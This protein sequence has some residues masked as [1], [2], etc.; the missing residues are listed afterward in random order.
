MKKILVFTLPLL[1]S[2]SASSQI[3]RPVKWSYAARKTAKTEAILYLLLK[4]VGISTPKTLKW[5]A[6]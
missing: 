1:L 2:L 6:L 5:V 3:L 4:T